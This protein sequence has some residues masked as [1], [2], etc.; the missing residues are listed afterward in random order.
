MKV[1]VTGGAGYIGSVVASELLRARHSVVVYDNMSNGHREAVPR[2]A[3]LVVGD[4]A[5]RAAL[6]RV[7]GAGG[8]DAVMHFA[9]SIEVGESMR[10]PER[11]FRNNSAA[12][13][14]LLEAML[15]NKVAG[16][17]VSAT[18]ALLGD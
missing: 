8:I 17:V 11:F 4:V 13:L 14:T 7:L 12:T 3:E 16:L 15:A 1:L 9:A 6:D 10:E 5:D 18:A 2:G